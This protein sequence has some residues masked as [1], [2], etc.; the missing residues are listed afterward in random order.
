MSGWKDRAG[1]PFA[2]EKQ[3]ALASRGMVVT[4]HPV[5][6]A[7]GAEMLLG[8]GNAIDAAIAALFTL[9][10]VEPM[11]VGPLGG[12]MAHIRLADGRH[13]V[14]DGI[15]TA[16]AAARPGMYRTVSDTLPDYQETE[17]LENKVGVLAMGV[18]G[19]L[20]GWCKALAGHGTL[21]LDEVLRPAIRAAAEGFRVTPYLTGAIHDAAGDLARDP[22]LAATF[23]PDGAPPA[24]GTLLRQPALA[25]SLRLIAEE[26]PSAL[27]GGALGRALAAH[28]AASGGLIT[29]ADL[30]AYRVAEREPVVG[31]Y[32]GHEVLSPP[33]P[34]SSGVH[35]T[36][37]LN[38]LEA[39]DI[40]ALGSGSAAT[41]HL[42]AEALKMAFAD[43]GAATADPAFIRV[44][45]DLLTSKDYAA[46]RRAL[47]REDLAQDWTAGIPPGE[48]LAES[49]NTT[50]VTV[51]DAAGNIVASTQTINSLFG[52][53][54][55]VPGTGLIANN[56][57][58]NFDPHPG[59]ALSVAPGKRVFTS[60][61]PT[62][63]RKDGKALFA[64]GLPG[65]LRIFGSAMQAVINLIDHGMELQDAVEAPRIWTQGHMLELE[66][67]VSPE[68][69]SRLAA[70]GHR[71]Q[72]VKH[73][74]GGMGAVR[75]HANGMIE[76]AAC[77][78]ADGTPVG[79]SGG[80]ARP[81]VR[82]NPDVVLRR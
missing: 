8:G 35:V 53:R 7:A 31:H 74:G 37:M 55:S 75:F 65:G 11:M 72:R 49:A 32:R 34:S 33:P 41:I 6:S 29:L 56:Y 63:V 18:P 4:N 21:P 17:G 12:G 9:T 46:T 70:L 39:Y 26:G 42:L 58:Y 50:H 64:L 1:S 2:R 57:M 14:L 3:P 78:R 67:T 79:I 47:L 48:I 52:A 40:A 5:A 61:A 25:E 28:M 20:A 19:A 38:L 73:I 77:W 81:D 71:V 54:F 66:P 59:R 27:Y 15:S 80:L 68:V 23:L 60:M 44:P 51:A 76:G 82:F 16:P 30:E 45:V 24:P 62:I 69:D 13:L 10:V 43:R 36:Q 22:G